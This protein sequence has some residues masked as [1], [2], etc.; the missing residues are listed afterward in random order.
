MVEMRKI[1][2]PVY[3]E[4]YY[5]SLMPN[6]AT[7]TTPPTHA[8]YYGHHLDRD[9]SYSHK[10]KQKSPWPWYLQKASRTSYEREKKKE[11][12]SHNAVKMPNHGGD[13]AMQMVK[14]SETERKLSVVHQR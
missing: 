14:V 6:P 11:K 8:Q 4:F 10:E 7:S 5:R 3:A 1:N 2:Y 12:K 9:V 13:D